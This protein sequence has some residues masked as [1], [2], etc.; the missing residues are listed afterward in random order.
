[1]FNL[2]LKCLQRENKL[3]QTEV[4]LYSCI[5]LE[6]PLR[7]LQG[8]LHMLTKT[9][10]MTTTITIMNNDAQCAELEW[11]CMHTNGGGVLW[12]LGHR[13]K[14]GFVAVGHGLTTGCLNHEA[15]TNPKC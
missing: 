10:V 3:Y 9:V 7:A 11:R 12:F 13:G 1:M 15:L 6:L 5:Q 14:A 4:K 2:E 8:E